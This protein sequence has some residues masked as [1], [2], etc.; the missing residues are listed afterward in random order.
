VLETARRSSAGRIEPVRGPINERVRESMWL[1]VCCLLLAMLA[2]VTRPGYILADTKI[3][4]ALDPAGFLARSFHLWD[5]IQF[6]ELQNQ[7]AG[8]FFPMGPF[9][10][11][12][13]L[14]AL[15]AWVVQRLW[16]TAIFVAAFLGV[17][18]LAARLGIGTAGSRMVAGLGYALSPIGLSSMG[19]L[20]AQFLPAAMLPWILLPLVRLMRE[21]AAMSRPARLQAIA[22][23]ALAVALCSGINAAAV[24][25][26]LLP[27]VIYL[28]AARRFWHRWRVLSWWAA[29]VAVATVWWTIPLLLLG[30]YGVSILPYSESA[31]VTTSVTS[32]SDAFR[33]TEYWLTYLVVNGSPWWP[34][35]FQ[36]ST[37]AVPTILTGLAAGLGLAGIASQRLP[38]RRF[39]L[40]AL[41]AGVFI[42][43]AGYLSGLGSPLA[44]TID[45]AINGPLAPLRNLAKFDPMIRLPIAL[46]LAQL[47]GSVRLPRMRVLASLAAAVSLAG[48]A[49]PAYL[50]GIAAA[51]DFPA[52]PSYWTSA[53]SWLNVHAGNQAVLAVPGARFGEYTWGRPMD[54]VLEAMFTGDWA[55]TQLATIGSV[56]STRLLDAVEQ[57]LDAGDGSA[58][59][60]QVLGRMGVKYIIVRNDLIR[61]DLYGAWPARIHD[62]L[63]SSPGIVKVAQFGT[64]P[65]GSSNPN[66]AVSSFDAPYPPVEIFKVTGA[67]PEAT[68]LPTAGTMRVYGGPESL[69]TLADYGRLQG[70]P[71]LLN[72]ASPSIAASQYVITDSLRKIVRNFG[73]IRVDY[74]QTLTAADPGRTIEATTDY[75]QPSWRSY[76]SVARYQ[77]IAG[78]SASSSSA[79]AAAL[80]NQS[81]TGLMP[82][83][84]LDGDPRTMWESGALT[85]PVGQWLQVDFEHP[86]PPRAISVTFADSATIGPPVTEVEVQTSAGSV[87]D[88]VRPTTS[89][90]SLAMPRGTARWLRITITGVAAWPYGLA[91]TQA[92]IAEIDVPGVTASRSIVAPDVAIPARAQQAVVL[93][94]AQPQPSDCMLTSLRWVCSPQLAQQTEEQYGFDHAFTA[95]RTYHA[96]LT[97]QAVLTSTPMITRYAWQGADQPTVT[98][99]S[100]YTSDPQ[101]MAESAFDGN[102]ATSWISAAT[103]QRPVLTIRWHQA[104]DVS[105]ITV[106]R[107]PSAASPL[108]V[109]ITGSSGQLRGGVIGASGR[110]SFKAMR[111]SELRLAFTPAQLPVQI[112]EVRIPGVTPLSSGTG[113]AAVRF[114][115]GQGPALKVDG[116]TVPTRAT[117]TVADLLEGRTVPF[118]ACSP[119]TIRRGGNGVV[120]AAADPT[121]FDVQS[122]MLAGPGAAGQTVRASRPEQVRTIRWTAASRLLRVSASERSFLVVDQNFN[123]GWQASVAG[124]ALTPVELDGWRQAW[125]L[126]AGTRGLVTLTY[127][128]DARYRAGLF[129]GLA[130]LGLVLLVALLPLRSR[131][132]RSSGSASSGVCVA[133]PVAPSRR[134]PSEAG[135]GPAGRLARA[136]VSA[137]A[138]GGLTLAGLWLGGY[139]GAALVPAATVVFLIAERRQATVVGWR[140]LASRWLLPA[141]LLAAAAGGAIAI[142]AQDWGRTTGLADFWWDKG[143]QLAGLIIVAR[144]AAALASAAGRD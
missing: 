14:I 100:T 49:L 33:G 68:V 83:S 87:A 37:G 42:V 107:P 50:G 52:V 72:S 99:S 28:L 3:D 43:S 78:V 103:D 89:P 1:V 74:S 59:L 85:G 44:A 24:A 51:G 34:V 16:L 143:P 116:V 12:G 139:P 101:D 76:L 102:L 142:A 54:D 10:V 67:Q 86:S 32:L 94:K 125:L 73:E 117:A 38:E 113:S 121:G 62:A 46:G 127:L 131:R 97:G 82:F 39:L 63:Y 17:V 96:A 90:Q 56:G 70:R 15:P 18:L 109:L 120:E 20:S 6:G 124:R 81:A 8:Y 111:T 45:H 9:F 27:A 110:L 2:F 134:W 115:C 21:G 66:D 40:W 118:T 58:G 57:Q 77:G 135:L 25:A 5:P 114:D 108:Q 69:L 84:A 60:A 138:L 79:D 22:R 106:V 61:S 30:K 75:L 119:V 19:I 47:L 23:S 65:A 122:V 48:L 11:L 136:G 130:L 128:P 80:P 92:G 123:A 26:V 133:D 132:L 140:L 105:H 144:L 129:G 88:A 93:S 141:L 29:A 4:M 36:L 7:S 31:A 126:P 104:R 98:A 35:G 53:T 55:A 64:F 112:A 91:G 137:V 13:K 95:S 41:L 71:V